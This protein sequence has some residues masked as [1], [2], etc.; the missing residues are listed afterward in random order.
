MKN[1]FKFP[2]VDNHIHINIEYGFGIEP[3]KTFEKYGG[4]HIF[5]VSLPSW[6]YNIYI[7]NPNDYKL[8]FEK[9]LYTASLISKKTNIKV[10]PILGVHPIEILYLKKN[11]S[12]KEKINIICK[13]LEIASKYIKEKKAFGLK[14]GRPHFNVEDEISNASNKILNYAFCLSKELNCPIQLHDK[15]MSFQNIYELYQISKKYNINQYKIINHHSL[16]YINIC[17]KYN[18]FP[19]ITAKL[20][21]IE[22][23]IHSGSRFVLE[24]DYFDDK[25]RP[26]A[27]L[28]TKT[29][30]KNINKLINIYGE[31]IFWK[32]NK[33]N[34]EKIY[35]IEIK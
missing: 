15:D 9:T 24:T 5:L 30:P 11:I 2:I 10:F 8:L 13:G 4:T 6:C 18:I 27:V 7:N 25:K 14:S 21:Y 20:N 31:E 35:D 12:I 34:I 17:K 22:N 3:I 16:P 23:A 1:T 26:G 32:I 33:E 19:S 29:I 28:S